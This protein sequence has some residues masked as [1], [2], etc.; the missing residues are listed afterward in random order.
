MHVVL[1]FVSLSHISVLLLQPLS[2]QKSSLGTLHKVPVLLVQWMGEGPYMRKPLQ[3]RTL[4]KCQSLNSLL[5]LN[6]RY[7]QLLLFWFHFLD[8]LIKLMKMMLLY[9]LYCPPTPATWVQ[10]SFVPLAILHAPVYRCSP[11]PL[12][13][14]GGGGEGTPHTVTCL[15]G[16]GR[17]GDRC[18][19]TTCG[20]AKDTKDPCICH[21][22]TSHAERPRTELLFWNFFIMSKS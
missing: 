21:V 5:T 16:M 11:H 13:H 20:M 4:T 19:T 6:K 12:V 14:L 8:L 17:G 1:H 2:I 10:G 18:K 22:D 9:I 7:I 15:A 3:V